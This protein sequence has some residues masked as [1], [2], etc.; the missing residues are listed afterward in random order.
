MNVTVVPTTVGGT[1]AALALAASLAARFHA[2]IQIVAPQVVPYPL[3][4]SRPAV[5]APFTAEKLRSLA[6]VVDLPTRVQI[7]V[8]RDRRQALEQ[9][10]KPGSLLLMGLDK[11]WWP[12]RDERLARWLTGKGHTV[13]QVS[14]NIRG[15]NGTIQSEMP[16]SSH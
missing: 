12:T 15:R 13:I 9:V 5:P 11:H 1:K 7:V 10:L 3:P 4:L 16:N 2:Y 8:C 14:P 6:S